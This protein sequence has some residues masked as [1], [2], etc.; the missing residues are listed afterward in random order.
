LIKMLQHIK[1]ILVKVFGYRLLLMLGDTLVLDRYFWLK[2]HLPETHQGETLL[3]VGCGSGAFTLAA[4]AR[5]FHSIGIS[6]D[7]R[8]QDEAEKMARRTHLA[9][10][11]KF[12]TLDIRKLDEQKS[13][14]EKF[15]F[16]INFENIEHIIDDRKL[17][18]DIYDCLK[19]GGILLFT[20]PYFFLNPISSSDKGPFSH[21]EDGGHVRRGY[22][23]TMLREL[24]GEAGF[25]IEQISGCS[26][27]FSQKITRVY[28][29]LFDI[30]PLLAW[31]VI[32]PLRP[33]PPLLDN[34]VRQ[35]FGVA[36][37]SVCMIAVKPRYSKI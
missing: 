33:L 13:F 6:W 9:D 32:L 11:A 28:R 12:K 26:G 21:I 15:N 18:I 1:V 34:L 22:T 19:P 14:A 10:K 7:E 5:G 23:W 35:I 29:A 16:C 37:Y 8:N 30:H 2:Q 25:E 3:D 20:S 31:L 4:A 17:M 36:D 27:Y 24:C